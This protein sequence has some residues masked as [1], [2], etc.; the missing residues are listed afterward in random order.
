MN[1]KIIFSAGG[2]GGHIIPAINIMKHFFDQGYKVKIV[3]DKRGKN[4]IEDFKE[5][6]S[7]IVNSGTPTNK[8]FIKKILSIFIILF[9]IIR[10]IFILKKERAD[11]VFGLGGYVSFPIA[12]ASKFL[13]IP[14]VIY[15]N[16]LV[17]GRANRILLSSSK[18]I[19]TAKKIKKNFPKKYEKKISQVG[20]ILDKKIINNKSIKKKYNSDNISILVLGGSQG[21]EIFGKIIPPVIKM[22]STEGYNVEVNQQCTKEQ[23]NSITDFY[24][25]NNIRNNIFKFSKNILNLILSS[26]L[27]ITRCGA[28]TT[29]ELVHL[30]TP[31]IA[32]PLPNSIDDHQYLNG[33]YYEQLG[34]CWFLDQDT[35]NSK[36]LYNLVI[37]IIKNKNKL[38]NIQKNMKKNYNIEVY[39]NIEKE[40]ESI[41]KYEN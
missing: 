34:C 22:I 5:F 3:T 8:N 1:K 4:F 17:L 41:I 9:S 10:S 23:E 24:R 40:I 31:F 26:D 16:N 25:K 38:E 35:F 20:S 27:V 2:T 28:S 7:Y 36:N 21:A 30:Q 19:F 12:F 6:E 15:E 13:N 11:L 37:D 14:L 39:K 33:K 29:A 32:V 18:K